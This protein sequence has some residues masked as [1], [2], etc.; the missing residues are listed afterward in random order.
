MIEK[1]FMEYSNYLFKIVERNYKL[2][3]GDIQI[4][5]EWSD[6]G[7]R[8]LSDNCEKF[9]FCDEPIFTMTWGYARGKGFWDKTEWH[10]EKRIQDF[11]NGSRR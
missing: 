8:Q 7:T 5:K 4:A 11:L 10:T 9:L 3:F 6:F 1:L 2:F